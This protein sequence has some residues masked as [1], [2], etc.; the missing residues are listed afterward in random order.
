MEIKDNTSSRQFETSY[1]DR[2]SN[3]NNSSKKS[4]KFSSD[5]H[6]DENLTI[7]G[8]YKRPTLQHYGYV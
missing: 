6:P 5:E 1:K 4:R 2:R 7:R 8:V 3:R